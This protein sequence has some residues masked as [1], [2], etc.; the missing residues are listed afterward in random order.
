MAW[1]AIDRRTPVIDEKAPPVLSE[2]VRAKIRSFFPRYE[3]KRAALLPAL[4]VVQN[5]LG[6]IG[7]QAMKEIAEL[8]EI[9]PSAVLD[10]LGFYT[11]FWDHPKGRKVVVA[12]RSLSCQLMGSD[13]VLKAIKDELGID[14]HGTTPDGQYSLITEE[15]LA[16]CD[17]APCLLINEKLHKRVKPEDVKRL[18]RDPE[19]DH[20]TVPRSDLYD[21]PAPLR[22]GEAAA[23]R[24]TAERTP[25]DP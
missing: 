10:T 22:S 1:K 5:A 24:T 21:R 12:C 11:H 18:L 13:A 9:T 8:L 2:A 25:D 19:N 3:T 17:H 6:Y 15:C 16:A 4:H 23:D 20:L 14:E 7:P